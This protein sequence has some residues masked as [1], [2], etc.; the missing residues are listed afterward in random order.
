MSTIAF[1]MGA[2]DK[3]TGRKPAW[4]EYG[5]DAWSYERGRQWA[6]IAPKRM[7]L[8]IKSKGNKLNPRAVELCKTM[9]GEGLTLRL[10]AHS[11]SSFSGASTFAPPSSLRMREPPLL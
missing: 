6:C 9:L 3:R 10:Y 1:A 11:V 7:P 2:Y 8:R 5:D 4:D